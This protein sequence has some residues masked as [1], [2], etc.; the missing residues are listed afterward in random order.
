MTLETGS[1][2]TNLMIGGNVTESFSNK[3]ND[4]IPWWTLHKIAEDLG[5]ELRQLYIQDSK[6]NKYKRIVIEYEDN[7]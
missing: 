3:G 7:D 4:S 2:K 5:G 6:G 1:N